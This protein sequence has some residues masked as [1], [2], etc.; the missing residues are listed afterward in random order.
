[1]HKRHRDN[2]SG[3]LEH[4]KSNSLNKTE[5]TINAAALGRND[6]RLYLA[7]LLF[8]SY[9]I[10]TCMSGSGKS[11]SRG[12]SRVANVFENL[13]LKEDPGV[14]RVRRGDAAALFAGGSKLTAS[15]NN[16]PRTL[17]RIAT[18]RVEVIIWLN[19]PFGI[20]KSTT[21]Q[22]LLRRFAEAVLFDPEPFGAA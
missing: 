7:A 15:L 6:P 4:G 12:L 2:M 1:M 22:A 13:D 3:H 16:R 10:P 20:G 11:P 18:S 19:G 17:A 14:A 8:Y 9:S 5:G 21:A